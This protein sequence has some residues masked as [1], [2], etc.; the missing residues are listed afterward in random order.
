MASFKVT[1]KQGFNL[2]SI[3][4]DMTGASYE[5]DPRELFPAYL[6]TSYIPN[7]G[8]TGNYVFMAISNGINSYQNENGVWRASGD[9]EN[10]WTSIT[11]NQALSVL[12]NISEPNGMLKKTFHG[13]TISSPQSIQYNLTQGYN[14]ISYPYEIDQE[15][16]SGSYSSPSI[17]FCVNTNYL[18]GSGHSDACITKI[19]AKKGQLQNPKFTF[20]LN[21]DGSGSNSSDWGK[22][23]NIQ[24]LEKF[25]AGTAVY[26]F[27]DSDKSNAT[28]WDN[29]SQNNNDNYNFLRGTTGITTAQT[30]GNRGMNVP[31]R[32]GTNNPLFPDHMDNVRIWVGGWPFFDND[33]EHEFKIKDASGND[34]YKVTGTGSDDNRTVVTTS[35]EY[36]MGFFVDRLFNKDLNRR[37]WGNR[38]FLWQFCSPNGGNGQPANNAS[39]YRTT[40]I[41]GYGLEHTTTANLENSEFFGYPE[42]DVPRLEMTS[43]ATLADMNNKPLGPGNRFIILRIDSYNSGISGTPS[44]NSPQFDVDDRKKTTGFRVGDHIVPIIYDPTATDGERYRFCKYYPHKNDYYNIRTPEGPTLYARRYFSQLEE[45]SHIFRDED[46]NLKFDPVLGDPFIE[47]VYKTFPY[48]IRDPSVDAYTN[49][50]VSTIMHINGIFQML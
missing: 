28:I 4:L 10:P 34:I 23:D 8:F 19:I 18:K 33:K 7:Q 6:Q 30:D 42:D 22:P 17:D 31:A 3:P 13:D 2:I 45:Y 32:G 24:E 37:N 35:T 44:L 40:E 38:G 39:G 9:S 20:G 27:S 48:E 47:P 12:V 11:T 50:Y 46:G 5:D 26:I 14:L 15:F 29:T 41:S 43:N 36:V 1:F 25:F 49:W 21:Y 16:G